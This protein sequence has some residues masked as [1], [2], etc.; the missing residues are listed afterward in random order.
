MSASGAKTD[1]GGGQC[2][3]FRNWMTR[4]DWRCGRWH[5]C[6]FRSDVR[7]PAKGGT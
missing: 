1:H 7:C 4:K 2:P 6:R 5:I 3:F